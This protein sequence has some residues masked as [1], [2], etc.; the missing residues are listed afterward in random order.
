MVLD[1][2]T[3]TDRFQNLLFA[4]CWIFENEE[5]QVD[6]MVLGESATRTQGERVRRYAER[7]GI[8]VLSRDTFIE[9]VFF[10][11]TFE[12]GTTLVCFNA[13]F[14]LSRLAVTAYESRTGGFTLELSRN[15]RWPR[16]RIQPLNSK[17]QFIR[18]VP[19]MN[20]RRA[21]RFPGYF[22]DLRQIVWALTG[23]S[24]SLAS[25]CRR[26]D[27]PPPTKSGIQHGVVTQSYLRYNETDV[28]KTL[29]LYRAVSDEYAHHPIPLL[30]NEAYSQ[31]SI[32]KAYL[33][34]MGIRPLLEKQ[35]DVSR[36]LLGI[37]MACYRGARAE[38]HVRRQ[39][40][41][42]TYL[43]VLSMYATV[44]VLQGLWSS[45]IADE[46]VAVEC[47]IEVQQL[48]ESFTERDLYDQAFWRQIPAFV[49]LVPDGDILPQRLRDPSSA[50]WHLA[51]PYVWSSMPQYVTLADILQDV[52]LTGRRPKVLRARRIEPR[53]I[54]NGLRSVKLLGEIEVDPACQD[55]FKE[56]IERRY[57]VKQQLRT[58]VGPPR[59]SL[60]RLDTGLKLLA[61]STS[62]GINMEFN[63]KDLR[64]TESVMVYG[65]EVYGSETDAMDEP[66]PFCNPLIA[67]FI[68][69][70]A[71]L[72]LG[73]MERF[74]SD[75][76]STFAFCD[77]DSMAVVGSDRTVALEMVER[78]KALCPYSFGGSILK[79]EDVNFA[80]KKR[81][82]W[83][84]L[85]AFAISAK[86]Y[87]LFEIEDGRARIVD[88]K[89]HGMG[90][91]LCPRKWK[92]R[93]LVEWWKEILAP[94][95]GLP[96]VTPT[97]YGQPAVG[98]LTISQPS[99]WRP[100]RQARNPWA[101]QIKPFSFMLVAYPKIA[102]SF[103]GH[104]V[105]PVAAFEADRGKWPSLQWLDL[106][107]GAPL[108]ADFGVPPA[109]L[110]GT[111]PM[112]TYDDVI[113]E[114]RFHPE[115]KAADEAGR[116]AGRDFV[117]QL[118]RLKVRVVDQQHIGKEAH[119][120]HVAEVLGNAD[121]MNIVYPRD[122]R[123]VL[124]QL[125]SLSDLELATL[126]GITRQQIH[127]LRKGSTKSARSNTMTQLHRVAAGLGRP[128]SH[129]FE[130][131][132]EVK[133]AACGVVPVGDTVHART[134]VRRSHPRETFDGLSA[135]SEGTQVTMSAIAVD[136]S[137]DLGTSFRIEQRD[138]LEFLA[139]LPDESIDIIVTDPA[140]SGMNQHMQFGH[141]RIVGRYGH[142]GAEGAKWFTEFADDADTYRR[143][144]KECYRV[145]RA[146]RHIYIMFDSYSLLTLGHV[147]REVFDVKN[148][149]VWD[150]V[151]LGMG[152]YFRRRHETVLFA[153]K[154]HRKLNRRD[155]ADVWAFKRIHRAPYPTQ[156]PV[157]LFEAMLVG[158]VEP[159]FVV[160]DPFVGS[161]SAAIAALKR[162]CSFVGAD[163]AE[164]AV[165]L[166]RQRCT[167]FAATGV[168]PLEKGGDQ[169]Q[170]SLFTD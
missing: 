148:L 71:W 98:Q 64:E 167:T 30:M 126:A 152:H 93:W 121:E 35:S 166:A 21:G 74:L 135:D 95:L 134:R 106:R 123:G 46:L 154:G 147:V 130:S 89:E 113:E 68:T 104:P 158:S 138:C 156:K 140:Y 145:L 91:L 18:F 38:V 92:T 65:T 15:L 100:F 39:V 4:R 96:S 42:V 141:G 142:A 27:I 79:V 102:A 116:P 94:V 1:C 49:E 163:I 67:P 146:D 43:D 118:G 11:E 54:Q 40:V 90:H 107:T 57:Q 10:P 41:P 73:M 12:L 86:R 115:S 51:H 58:A 133:T 2:E 17:A 23:E 69:S 149:I 153:S 122:L 34:E 110:Q 44:F 103:D 59:K 7:S 37:A 16:V 168:D 132:S 3:T 124:D 31:A 139:S 22:V 125:S 165:S 14:D 150:K 136:Q 53:G 155:L 164:K 81:T 170:T 157:A 111:I 97:W 50:N 114:Y 33:R 131:P 151:N 129:L 108:I 127:N 47:T 20:R 29:E 85:H 144:L 28:Q 80:D 77:T 109:Y 52:L 66:G 26:F 48:I 82:I 87:V 8:Q 101:K 32:G 36:D 60:M 159:G 70:A 99:L 83:R 137:T 84:E 72:I 19:A 105:R 161:G 160:C 25:A 75:R 128:G 45:V 55:F 56:V 5:R 63:R 13:P 169:G 162:D 112:Q 6:V 88:P 61:N 117:G 119:D 76:G 62:Y 78:F 24:H 9:E 120:L 143:F